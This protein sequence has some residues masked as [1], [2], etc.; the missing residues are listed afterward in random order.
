MMVFGV[1]A[2]LAGLAG[3]IAGP[4]AGDAADHGGAARADPVRRRRRRRPRLA[5]R[6]LRRLAADRPRAD[7]R[8]RD[9][10]LARR[11][12]SA[13][14][15]PPLLGDLWHVTVAQIAPILP[16]LLLV[17]MLILRPTRPDGDAR[18]RERARCAS[19]LACRS[20]WRS[21]S[22]SRRC[23]FHLRLRADDDEPDRRHDHVRAV[24]QHAARPD[25]PAVVR[26]RGLLRARRLLS[27]SMR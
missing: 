6:R 16:Y 11:A 7:L 2:A 9:Q 12:C 14:P 13:R 15:A 18:N 5:G 27:R 26:P 22:R 21:C 17:L 4:G 1:G 20:R 23:V 3:V 19:A 25:R 10:R 24:L 8:G